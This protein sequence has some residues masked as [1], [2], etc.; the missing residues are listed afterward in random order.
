MQT[1]CRI[2]EAAMKRFWL[3]LNTVRYLK[4]SQLFYQVFY[5]VRKRRSK[6]QSEPELRGA[7]G[8]WPGAQFLQPASVD[9]KTFT[10]LGQT[11]RLGD[12]WNHPSFP[13]LWLYNLHYQDDLNA[14]GSEDRRELSEYL[15]DS[16][17]AAN[18]PAEGNGWEPYCLSL[19]LVNWVKWFCRLES[20]HLKREWLISLSRQADSLERQ[21]EF[22]ILANHLFAN[23]KA[24][25]FVGVFLGGKQGNRYLYRGLDLLGKELKEQFLADGAHYEL[26]PMY[27]SIL[28]W[29]VAD[30][31]ALKQASGLDVLNIEAK[32]WEERFVKG[33]EWLRAMV[34][35][36]REIAFFNDA[37]LGIAPTLEDLEEYGQKLGIQLPPSHT[38]QT[39]S[40]RILQASGYS[41]IDWPGNHRLIAD[42][43]TVGPDYQ[44]GHAH[45]DT[46]SFEFSLFGQRVF[47]NSGI[48]Q[49]GD[50][51]ERY[52]QRSTAAHNTVEVDGENSSEV[53]S[54][55]RVARRARPFDVKIDNN[56][57]GISLQASHDGYRRLR[58]KVIHCRRWFATNESLMIEDELQGNFQRAVAHF[59]FHPDVTVE[60]EGKSCFR[61]RLPD[62]KSLILELSDSW[63]NLV[64]SHWHPGFGVSQKIQKLSVEFSGPRLITQIRWS[65]S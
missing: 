11:A 47:V 6:I 10:F 56:H 5:R 61:I 27:H 36:D 51:A 58:G 64:T 44:P 23:A 28:M 32:V 9:G 13:K 1:D 37:T 46:L 62:G 26:S 34:H 35:P 42:V 21:L 14:K 54:G 30:L 15:I 29:D 43:A 16:W 2:L 52:R 18:P 4:L 3:L 55:F 19:R 12:D 33:M 60:H 45:A 31:L 48:S 59:H 8:P 49:Y 40:G 25:V 22:H 63:P 17:I 20:Q 39:L 50:D 41:I 57:S 65:S 24:L 7:L 53:W 38:P